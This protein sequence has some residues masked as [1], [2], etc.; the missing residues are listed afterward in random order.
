[1]RPGMGRARSWRLALRLAGREVL[2][3]RGR[4]LLVL[5]MIA[6]PVLA[7]TAADVLIQTQDVNGAESLDRRLG[8]AAAAQVVVPAGGRPMVQAFDPWDGSTP[9]GRT[10]PPPTAQDVSAALGGARLVP[11]RT[12]GV[13]VRTD[14]GVAYA[15]ALEVDLRDPIAAGLVRLTSGRL[16]QSTD[17]VVVNQALLDEGYAVGDRLGLRG[18]DR[19]SPV[20]VGVAE[21]REL[22]SAPAAA[23]PVG[24]L[25]LTDR[26]TGPTWL[27][28]GAPDLVGHRPAAQRARRRRALPRGRRGPATGVAAAGPDR[29]V[30]HGHRQHDGRGR[31]PG[32]GDGAARGGAAGRPGV[33]GEC[34]APGAQP[35]PDGRHGRHPD[36]G[37]PR[38]PGRWSR[39]RERGGR[40]RCR[41]RDRRRPAWSSRSC[42]AGRPRGSGR[43]T[44]RGRTCSASP[45]SGWSARCS[46]RSS[47][48]GSRPARTSSRCSPAGGPTARRPCAHRCSG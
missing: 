8:D 28:G 26:G 11:E 4:S 36:A 35:R 29:F 45:G 16:P 22:R 23:G 13:D 18:K 34:P 41:G 21:S 47:R 42:S 5:L 12:G 32:R 9:V 24:S 46:P 30:A 40:H 37:P 19:P 7:V 17:E 20:I 39:A 33:C 14:D 6:L 25:G 27:A 10:Q 31:R 15:E 43:S 44:C 3:A 2:R 48:R 38:R 1:M